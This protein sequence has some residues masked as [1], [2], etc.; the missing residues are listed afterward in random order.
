MGRAACLRV[1]VLSKIILDRVGDVAAPR[2]GGGGAQAAVGALLAAGEGECRLL[3]PAGIDLDARLLGELEA[4]GVV[5]DIHLLPEVER[6]PGEDI[7]YDGEEMRWVPIGWEDWGKLTEWVPPVDNLELDALHVLVEGGGQGEVEAALR[8]ASRPNPPF[9]SL[10]PVMH[11]VDAHAV[12]G[13][14]R[15]SRLADVIS[16]DLVT[17]THIA[18]LASVPLCA[19]SAIGSRRS[20]D[21]AIPAIARGCAHALELREDAVLAIRDGRRG[22]YL[23]SPSYGTIKGRQLLHVPSF[24]VDVIDP[25][26]AGN[27]YAGA[28][29]ATLAM[30]MGVAEAATYASAVGAAFVSVDSWAPREMRASREWVREMVR[31]RC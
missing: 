17:A 13:L 23:L 30:G 4:R 16:P 18:T 26:G 28:I 27:A 22:S 14:Q 15:V 10:E 6:T 1:C 9:L 21:R 25:T 24:S 12:E 19:N 11:I 7:V 2:I 5:A 8:C 3:A 29:C 20:L 31:S